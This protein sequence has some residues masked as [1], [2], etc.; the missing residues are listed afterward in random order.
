MNPIKLLKFL[1]LGFAVAAVATLIGRVAGVPWLERG[2]SRVGIV[3]C[4]LLVIVVIAIVIA[5]LVS[6]LRQKK[7]KGPPTA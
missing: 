5:V 4:V 6:K 2:A 7:S 3:L 1:Y